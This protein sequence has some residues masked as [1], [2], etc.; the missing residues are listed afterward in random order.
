MRTEIIINKIINIDDGSILQT[1]SI[2]AIMNT[3]EERSTPNRETAGTEMYELD[4]N[5]VF[6]SRGQRVNSIQ[7]N[8]DIFLNEEELHEKNAD[9]LP[10]TKY[11]TS[12][13]AHNMSGC[14]DVIIFWCTTYHEHIYRRQRI[15]TLNR[16]EREIESEQAFFEMYS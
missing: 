12:S 5:D 13:K 9:L 2:A 16:A 14:N 11:N 7:I 1:A 6:V 15:S 3:G 8:N 4:H 10:A